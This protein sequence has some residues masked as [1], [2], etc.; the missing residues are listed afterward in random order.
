[1]NRVDAF[2]QFLT[3]TSPTVGIGGFLL[4]LIVA[5][6][7]A[8]VLRYVYIRYGQTLGN[9]ERFANT[10]FLLATTTMIIITI[11]KSSLALSLGLV[12]ALSIVRFRAAIKEPEELAYL[13]LAIAIGL[14]LGADQ[15]LI[16]L[17]G[18]SVIVAVIWVKRRWQKSAQVPNLV[19]S[20]QADQAPTKTMD[21]V[22]ALAAE[23][24][25]VKLIRLDQGETYH[26]SFLIA[27]PAP[28]KV[29]ALQGAIQR[30][31]PN[32][33]LSYLDHDRLI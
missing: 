19:M 8:Y 25:S 12:G 7:L 28:E 1:M 3:T 23:C 26:A 20:V 32:A 27:L 4:N 14:G 21:L 18:F 30:I 17:G 9:R 24:D 15:R 10:F 22:S 6:I 2:Q 29:D 5:G 33:R 11:V 16:V 31:V 13:F